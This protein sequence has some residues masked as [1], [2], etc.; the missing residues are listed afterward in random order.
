MEVT[1]QILEQF[2]LAERQY[3]DLNGVQK[4]FASRGFKLSD[5]I[6]TFFAEAV[7]D[8]ARSLTQLDV[9]VFHRVQG[10]WQCRDYNGSDGSIRHQ[11]NFTIN[12]IV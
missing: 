3:T 4:V 2:P 9:N 5:G 6:D 11:N 10:S 8:Y 12:K 1:V 7:G